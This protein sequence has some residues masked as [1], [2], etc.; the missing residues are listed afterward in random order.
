MAPL[1]AEIYGP[2]LAGSRRIAGELEARLRAT[3]GI[4]DVDSTVE[5][6]A[7]RD[8]VLVDRDRAAR[9]GVSQAQIAQTL[10]MAVSA[11]FAAWGAG[12]T[13]PAPES[14]TDVVPFLLRALGLA[15]SVA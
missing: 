6:D 8:R 15:T 14:L 11:L 2:D 13:G 10:A 7:P 9:L 4:V 12:A 3:E 1:V 5:A